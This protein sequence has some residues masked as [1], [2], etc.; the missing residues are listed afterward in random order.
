VTP[1]DGCSDFETRI[2]PALM[3]QPFFRLATEDEV[4]YS[5]E[6]YRTGDP[7]RLVKVWQIAA[8]PTRASLGA[9]GPFYRR[10]RLLPSIWNGLA[11]LASLRAVLAAGERFRA[12]LTPELRRALATTFPWLEHRHE[13]VPPGWTPELIFPPALTA[14]LDGP[15]A[16]A[17]ARWQ[18]VAA[19]NEVQQA[20]YSSSL[21]A[22]F[23]LPELAA[24]AAR[25]RELAVN[26]FGHWSPPATLALWRQCLYLLDALN[27]AVFEMMCRALPGHMV[28]HS[29]VGALA[30]REEWRAFTDGL[31]RPQR[32][33]PVPAR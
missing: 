6:A 18:L 1:F 9:Y 19:L 15:T 29:V 28:A 27:A 25:E 23:G 22:T 31:L 12:T 11:F 20:S 5:Y 8:E 17:R 26:Y 3:A 13:H 10:A 2:L 30:R 4:R 14:F 32:L 16:E 33:L 21:V 7:S 24:H